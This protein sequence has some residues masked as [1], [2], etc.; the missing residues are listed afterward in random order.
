MDSQQRYYLNALGI[1][2]WERRDLPSPAAEEETAAEAVAVEPQAVETPV[3]ESTPV[4]PKPEPAPIAPA[5]ESKPQP[6]DDGIPKP[7]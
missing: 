4:E 1:Q 7:Q 5:A 2:L 6:V 3:V